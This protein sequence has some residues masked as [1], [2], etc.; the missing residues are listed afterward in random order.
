MGYG[1]AR[2]ANHHATTTLA[3]QG[4]GKNLAKRATPNVVDSLLIV[5]PG[6]ATLPSDRFQPIAPASYSSIRPVMSQHSNF[7]Y[8]SF[9][10]FWRDFRLMSAKERLANNIPRTAKVT[11]NAT[12]TTSFF[13][14]SQRLNGA[15]WPRR[16]RA[17]GL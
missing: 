16:H 6:V 5:A 1:R 3:E 10:R 14:V 7:I 12:A 8:R 9:P 17:P 15:I 2:T 13:A 11:I 4:I